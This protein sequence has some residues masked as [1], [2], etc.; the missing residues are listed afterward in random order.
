[1]NPKFRHHY[2]VIQ[3]VTNFLSFSSLEALNK[4]MGTICNKI[5]CGS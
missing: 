3:E 1:M 2:E 5:G 4:N